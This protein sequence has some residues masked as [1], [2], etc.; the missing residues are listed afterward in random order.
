MALDVDMITSKFLG[1]SSPA[2][3]SSVYLSS[4]K[5]VST[6]A[7]TLGST[8]TT[9]IPGSIARTCAASA[10]KLHLIEPLGFDQVDDVI[11]KMVEFS[12]SRI[13]ILHSSWPEFREYFKK[14]EGEKRLLALFA[15]SV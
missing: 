13:G 8:A 5:E 9:G 7:A 12:I 2:L 14:Q 4:T 3:S 15:Y 10:V 6:R 1:Y 11:L